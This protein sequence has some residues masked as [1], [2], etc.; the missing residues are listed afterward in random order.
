MTGLR[1]STHLHRRGGGQRLARVR[2]D[3][4]RSSHGRR[5][6]QPRRPARHPA[7]GARKLI[8][9]SA[10]D[11]DRWLSAKSQILSTRTVADLKSILRRAITRAQ[12]RD[13]VKRNVVLLCGTP[14]GQVGRPSKALTLHQAHA[15][16]EHA[17]GST[18]GAYVLVSL[19]TGA[20]T[21][22]LRALTWSHL[23]LDGSPDAVPPVL[24]VCNWN[25][26]S[27]FVGQ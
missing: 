10:E 12:A 21:E 20:R 3:W 9:L 11:V 5:E 1:A 16:V 4:T 2:P 26:G 23:D 6:A 25:G 27:G 17:G 7:L 19:L 24:R 8:E 13:K 18:M 22:E 15:L 14:A